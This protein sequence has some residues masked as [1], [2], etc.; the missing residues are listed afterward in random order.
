M[1]LSARN[2]A[3]GKV[4]SVQDGA[5]ATVVKVEVRGP[6]LVTSMITKEASQDLKL[7]QGDEVSVIIKSTEVIIA[8]E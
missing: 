4:T 3:K 1:K 5:V 8:K 2:Q 7:K 6:L